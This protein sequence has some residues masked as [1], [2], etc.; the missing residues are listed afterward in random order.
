MKRGP[1]QN[2]KI[3][4]GIAHSL[5]PNGKDPVHSKDTGWDLQRECRDGSQQGCASPP[6]WAWAVFVANPPC[7]RV[8]SQDAALLMFRN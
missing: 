5:V 3:I 8:Y 4:Y 6:N 7:V 2:L 1:F